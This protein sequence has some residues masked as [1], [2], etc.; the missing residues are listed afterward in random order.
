[1]LI[2]ILAILE[3][4]MF[5]LFTFCAIFVFMVKSDVRT[6]LS[7]HRTFRSWSHVSINSL[8]GA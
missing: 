8:G 5:Y 3:A 6:N 1:M 2:S 4:S 7:H